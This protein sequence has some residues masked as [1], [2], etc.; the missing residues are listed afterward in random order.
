MSEK[1]TT[2]SAGKGDASRTKQG[3]AWREKYDTIFR[4]EGERARGHGRV[5]KKTYK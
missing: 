2:T 4:K 1:L 5:F 3:D